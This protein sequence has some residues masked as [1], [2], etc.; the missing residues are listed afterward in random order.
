MFSGK[1]TRSLTYFCWA[2]CFFECSWR[3]TLPC[4][5]ISHSVNDIQLLGDM[6]LRLVNEALAERFFGKSY[7]I[8]SY[9]DLNLQ[10][11]RWQTCIHCMLYHGKRNKQKLLP[12]RIHLYLYNKL[13]SPHIA[14]MFLFLSLSSSAISPL[15]RE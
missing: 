12:D 9:D 14:D 3:V 5:L 13:F 10:L 2:L 7:L 6:L 1:E 4:L 15:K 11:K 8:K